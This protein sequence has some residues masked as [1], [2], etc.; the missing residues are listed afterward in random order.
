MLT[1]KVSLVASVTFCIIA[2]GATFWLSR[3][4]S[5]S[6]AK[7]SES[8]GATS[9]AKDC[10]YTAARLKGYQYIKPLLDETP[11]CEAQSLAPLKQEI[12]NYIDNQKQGG[13]ITSASV[14]IKE[15][16]SGDWT[17]INPGETYLPGSLFKLPIML[18][19]LRMAEGNPALLNKKITFDQKHVVN[20]PQTYATKTIEP[21]KSYTVKELLTYMIAYSD[22]NATQLLNGCMDPQVLVKVFSDVGLTP[23]KPDAASYLTYTISPREY[24]VFMAALYNASYLTITESEYATS[25]LAQCN[26]KAGLVSGLPA[27]V[28]IAHKFGEA[29]NQQQH[30]LHETGIVYINNNAYLITVMTR[31]T[32][33]KNLLATIGN[34]SK[35]TY[36]KLSTHS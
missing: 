36:N 23:P 22:N 31:G 24:S 35:I 28:R 30:E 1:K 13:M 12:T 4:Y 9:T 32:D 34:I 5:A 8:A 2:S 21:G 29:G 27:N 19:I 14:Y 20:V 10:N 26:F 33:L 16:A 3:I 17:Y 18:T 7:A 6:N 15:F 25:L 11:E